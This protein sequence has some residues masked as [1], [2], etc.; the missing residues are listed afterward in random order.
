MHIREMERKMNRAKANNEKNEIKQRR[1]LIPL[2]SRD[3]ARCK[4]A[5]KEIRLQTTTQRCKKYCI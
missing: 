3:A 2:E 1:L 4:T 5:S